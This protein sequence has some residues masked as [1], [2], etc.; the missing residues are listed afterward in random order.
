MPYLR[1]NNP[2]LDIQLLKYPHIKRKRHIGFRHQPSNLSSP[3]YHL[4]QRLPIPVLEQFGRCH[5]LKLIKP[6]PI[7]PLPQMEGTSC[8]PRH[9]LPTAQIPK[10]PRISMTQQH[11]RI[12]TSH[13]RHATNVI[14]HRRRRSHHAT[15]LH[16]PLPIHSMPVFH[17]FPQRFHPTQLLGEVHRSKVKRGVKVE[18]SLEGDVRVIQS[19]EEVVGV[20]MTID[21]SLEEIVD[22][23]YVFGGGVGFLRA[24]FEGLG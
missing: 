17:I 23:V 5:V 14:L 2:T 8:N 22:E 16:L 3:Q 24:C 6:Q 7:P 15:T 21:F 20:E 19:R 13:L 10:V 12:P 1:S 4:I 9:H 11:P 18:Q